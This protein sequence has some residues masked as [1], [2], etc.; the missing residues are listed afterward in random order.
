[1]KIK[2]GDILII[3]HARKGTFKA[4]AIKDFDTDKAEFYPVITL[5]TVLSANSSRRWIEGKEIP[6][7]ASLCFISKEKT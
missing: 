6:C 3:E 5:E 7:R 1:M 4:K 2:K